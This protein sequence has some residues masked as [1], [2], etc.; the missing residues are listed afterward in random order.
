MGQN[1]GL[2]LPV[3]S[4]LLSQGASS[5][6]AVSLQAQ[7]LLLCTAN[8]LPQ[9]SLSLDSLTYQRSQDISFALGLKALNFVS[10]SP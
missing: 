10:V 9:G 1:P 8:L 2:P 3:Q 7:E 6:P 5:L 4:G